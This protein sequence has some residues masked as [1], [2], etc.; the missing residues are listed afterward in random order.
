MPG[1]CLIWEGSHLLL[2]MTSKYFAANLIRDFIYRPAPIL[3]QIVNANFIQTKY[4]NWKKLYE[5]H[6]KYRR[7]DYLDASRP[8]DE[9]IPFLDVIVF[10]TIFPVMQSFSHSNIQNV[11]KIIPNMQF[12]FL[13]T[14]LQANKINSRNRTNAHNRLIFMLYVLSERNAFINFTQ[15]GF[16]KIHFNSYYVFCVTDLILIA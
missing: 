10:L 3:F 9:A 11:Q 16:K 13:Q 12:T 4:L 7:I 8:I 15:F 5:S 6:E 14:F 1:F 2:Q